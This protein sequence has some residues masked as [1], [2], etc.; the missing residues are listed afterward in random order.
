M[1]Q[2]HDDIIFAPATPRSPAALSLIRVSGG[3]ALFLFG[4]IFSAADALKRAPSHTIHYGMIRDPRSGEIVDDV[5]LS[6]FRAP[7]SY[8]GEDAAEISCH[9]NPVIVERILDLLMYAGE[10]PELK[11]RLAPGVRARLAEPGEFTRRAFLNGRMDLSR[12][13][14]VADLI[15]AA[16]ER[17]LSLARRQFAG[18]F[19]ARMAR[20]R[21]GLVEIAALL[22]FGLDF[23]EEG[24]PEN[25]DIQR[26]A[27]T[28]MRLEGFINE[29]SAFIASYTTGKRIREG[30]RLV[31]AGPPN[32]GKS[33][34][35]NRLL[36]EP[37]AIVSAAPGTTRDLIREDIRLDGHLLCL[38]DTAG[39]CAEARDEIEKEG[40]MRTRDELARAD[41]VLFLAPD[42]EA[43]EA[44]A[45]YAD[46]RLSAAEGATVIRVRTKADLLPD[47]AR[48][49]GHVCE[50]SRADL[51]DISVL[52]EEGIDELLSALKERLM[53]LAGHDAAD[54]VVGSERQRA[55][56]ESAL[57]FLHGAKDA[58]AGGAE[59]LASLDIRH[60]AAELAGIV[61][62]I[63][64][65]EILD[66]IFARF[67]VGK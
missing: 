27:Q 52:R 25:E 57:R 21:E 56:L 37:R 23:P 31:I 8:T 28:H 24:A 39:L 16:S 18:E 55:S 15:S 11:A 2:I 51:I 35:F 12:A 45:A 3:G 60:A 64:S 65:D 61:G 40:M 17:A 19:S 49:A 26:N 53:L 34:L 42:H 13:E 6:V 44:H 66:T 62:I 10:S 32:A 1:P 7:H 58:L 47:F 14:A 36:Q 43:K 20:I 29:L 30:A 33:S 41:I 5:L 22:E 54:A 4:G 67:C 46:V 63:T 48:R 38:Y 50:A 9:G 59:E